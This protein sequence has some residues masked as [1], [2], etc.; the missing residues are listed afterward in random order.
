MKQK[1]LRC[2]LAAWA[3]AAAAIASGQDSEPSTKELL[4]EL[5][6]LKERVETL[7]TRHESDQQK[8]NELEERL[9]RVETT[10]A[11]HLA[12]A[13]Q[14]TGAPGGAEQELEALLGTGTP[15]AKPSPE[16][17]SAFTLGSIG[18]PGQSFNPDISLNGDF[19]AAYS[20]REGGKVDDEFLFRELEMGFSGAVDPYT[21]ADMIVTVG[22]EDGEFKADLEEAYLTFL[23]L[24]YN[25]QARAGKFR[26]EF[27]RANPIHLHA[28]PWIDYPFVIR[29]YFGDE[30]LS[31]T[32]AELSWLIP[33]PWNQYMG[34]TYELF[35]NDND[36]I[37]AGQEGDDFTH[38]FRFKTSR[39]LSQAS[40]VDLGASIATAP[41]DG[42]HGGHRATVGGVD[43]TYH[44]KPKGQGLYRS[45]LLQSEA[46]ASHTETCHGGES[47]WGMYSAAEYQF[48]RRWKLGLRYDNT[49]LPNRSSRHERGYSAYLTFLQSEFLFWRLGYIYTDRN[50]EEDG[51][52]DDQQVML[53]L[54]WTLGAHPAHK[55]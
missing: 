21:R 38:L 36:T 6:H 5:R 13:A 37:F 46:Y 31:G 22:R 17:K 11:D 16:A 10:Q 54:N 9:Q 49:E 27:G 24:P 19:V 26:A 53:Q 3:L 18:G 44:W 14:P 29:R 48:A 50:F 43:L 30:G 15:R 1:T 45:L 20:N 33:N 7:E 41:N 25:L 52:S 12:P 55:F 2:A 35:N 32:G 34:L 40:T 42:G 4:N 47:A 28:V 8:I 23:Q 39:D 51:N